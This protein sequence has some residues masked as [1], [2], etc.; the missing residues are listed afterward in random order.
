MTNHPIRERFRERVAEILLFSPMATKLDIVAAVD[1]I[2]QAA[3]PRNDAPV[4]L[5][6]CKQAVGRVFVPDGVWNIE[7]GFKL[8]MAAKAVLETIGVKYE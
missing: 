1:A 6:K 2:D 4:S 3:S 5:E 7:E 8:E